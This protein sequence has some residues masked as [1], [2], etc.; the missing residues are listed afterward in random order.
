MNK[1]KA[2]LRRRI[3]SVFMLVAII[4]SLFLGFFSYMN[5]ANALRESAKKN[6]NNT[7]LQVDNNINILL[8]S[9]EDVLYQVYTSDDVIQNMDL[10]NNGKNSS[11]AKN[12]LRRYLRNLVNSKDYIRSITLI[13]NTGEIVAYDQMTNKTYENGWLEN[14]SMDKESL[15]AEISQNALLHI[16]SPEY[17]TT[18]ANEEYYLL[19]LGHRL[20]D[21]KDIRRDVGVVVLSIDERMIQNSC[22]TGEESGDYIFIVDGNGKIISCGEYQEL[23]GTTV[24][25]Q[26]PDG[27]ALFIKDV[28]NKENFDVYQYTDEALGWNII[29]ADNNENLVEALH[30]QLQLIV[31]V[32]IV[33]FFLISL[34]IIG[35]TDRLG[36]SVDRVVEGMK[37]AQTADSQVYVEIDDSMP[38]EIE[39]IAVGFNEMIEKL[40]VANYSE[41]IAMIKQKEAQIAAL[42]AQINPHFLYNTLDTINWMAIDKDEYEISNAIGALASILRYA[43]SDSNAKVTVADEV[44]WLKKYIFLQQVRLK[45]KFICNIDI[46]PETNELTVHKLLLQPFIEN[47]IIHGFEREQEECVLTITAVKDSDLVITIEDNG[48]GIAPDIVEKCNSLQILNEDTTQHIG[49]GNAITRIRMYYGELAEVFVE[50]VLGNGSKITIT[51][52]V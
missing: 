48:K 51:I 49:M 3:I 15:Y 24:D 36:K 7:L 44:E 45:N 31:V 27:Y 35:L 23:I 40:R 52:P 25:N 30:S 28:L 47:A 50:S 46:A 13:S 17:G 6:S 32:E 21:Y 33:V 26:S 29:C 38:L 34:I 37:S 16:F 39:T 1:K 43:I 42:E 22:V 5:I 10:I 11:V 2:S 8:D 20:I 4:S 9:Y 12:S 14:Y 18:F 41:R 19:H